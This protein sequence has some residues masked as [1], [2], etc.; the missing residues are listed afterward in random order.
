MNLKAYLGW[1]TWT[2]AICGG[3]AACSGADAPTDEQVGSQQED[4]KRLKLCGGPR[5]RECGPK[6]FCNARVG[7]C[8]D[9]RQFGRCERVPEVCYK[10]YAP[11][12]GCDGVTYGNDCEAHAAGVSIA[13]S[14]ECAPKP[15]FCGGIAGIACP[16]GQTCVDD[17]ND[18][19]DPNAGGADCGGIC[20]DQPAPTF[21]GG[22]AGIPCPEGQSCVDDPSDDCDPK[23]GGADCGGICVDA[24]APTFCGGIAGIPCPAGQ[25]CVD[26]PSDSC[27]PNAGG[28]D[29]G[30]ICVKGETCG[31]VQCAPGLVCCNPLMN[32]CTKPGMVCIQ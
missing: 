19:C 6:R 30:G 29:C 25:S 7:H 17:P 9:E 20:V 8:P 12:C 15:T 2:V 22:I 27:D 23:A 24:P 16:D 10:I 3:V 18:S 31:D 14:G 28:A 21:C 5:E 4:L 1:A 26:D 11:V 32:I 13:Q